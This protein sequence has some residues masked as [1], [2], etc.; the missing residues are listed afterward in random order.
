MVYKITV[1]LLF[2]LLFISCKNEKEVNANIIPANFY[3]DI[4]SALSFQH[5]PLITSAIEKPGSEYYKEVASIINQAETSSKI[6]SDAI[7][8]LRIHNLYQASTFT[9]ISMED[10]RRKDIEVRENIYKENRTWPYELTLKDQDGSTALQFYWS[11]TPLRGF[12][13]FN[14]TNHNRS[15]LNYPSSAMFRVDYSEKKSTFEKTMEISI[16]GLSV[17][18]SDTFGISSM[19]L[20]VGKNG[21]LLNIYGNTNHPE[22]TLSPQSSQHGRNYSFTAKGNI[23]LNIGTVK[24]GLPPSLQNSNTT[25]MTDYSLYNVLHSELYTAGISDQNKRNSVLNEAKSP[26]FF[27]N[28]GFIK[29]ELPPVNAG[30]DETMINLNDLTPYVPMEISNLKVDFK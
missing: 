30:F 11:S 1:T 17:L 4:N 15:N 29:V 20:F 2:S 3:L 14:P 28:D 9:Y 25:I 23:T 16:A 12:A 5:N 10:G 26:G 7:K 24:V 19:K 8:N 21:E 27:T 18:P 13:I 22:F 6:V